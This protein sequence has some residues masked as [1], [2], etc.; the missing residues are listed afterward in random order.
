MTNTVSETNISD[1]C[2]KLGEIDKDLGYIYRKYGAPPLW[3]REPDYAT[4]IHIILEQQVSL[5]SALSAFNKLKE[6]I[7]EITPR[8][9]LKLN[10]A[11]MK[12]CYF[13]RQKMG[14]ARNLAEAILSNDLVLKDLGKLPDEEAGVEL[15]K[16]KGIGRWTA[17]IYLIMVLL[18]PDIMPKGDIALHVSY[19]NLKK[20][21][22]RPGSDEFLEMTEI[23]KP[24]R[25]VAARLLWHFYLCE[26]KEKK[27]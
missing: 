15:M 5:A 18:R 20:L 26:K 16:I 25:S 23:W 4:L 19:K 13:S 27:K 14:Y 17:D 6:K 10:D 22:K 11:E 9:L 7:G 24:Y 1:C 3:G 21:D 2:L 8:N 12:A